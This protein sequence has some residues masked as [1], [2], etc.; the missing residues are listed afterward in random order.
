[1]LLKIQFSVLIE[2]LKAKSQN[3]W[4]GAGDVGAFRSNTPHWLI[5]WELW[6]TDDIKEAVNNPG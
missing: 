5:L 2:W 1:M 3:T 6:S 4:A